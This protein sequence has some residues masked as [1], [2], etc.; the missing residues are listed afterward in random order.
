MV[1]VRPPV[2]SVVHRTDTAHRTLASLFFHNVRD[3]P[4]RTRN[5][6][7]AVERWGLIGHRAGHAYILIS[8]GAAAESVEVSGSGY[9]LVQLSG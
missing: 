8:T 3:E 9:F 7:D 5:H 4:W 1:S 2:I 6:G